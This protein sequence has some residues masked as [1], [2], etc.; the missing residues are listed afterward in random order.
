MEETKRKCE[1]LSEVLKVETED[2][3]DQVKGRKE[4][5]A[6]E[7]EIVQEN[8]GTIE[9]EQLLLQ[10]RVGNLEEMTTR[11]VDEIAAKPKRLKMK[12]KKQ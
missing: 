6:K 2:M 1:E 4:E 8:I 5:T 10:T 9:D 7:M 3:T 12:W 11:R